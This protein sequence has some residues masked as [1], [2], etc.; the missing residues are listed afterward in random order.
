MKTNKKQTRIY[1][2]KNKRDKNTIVKHSNN[3]KY[4]TNKQGIIIRIMMK[5]KSIIIKP[6]K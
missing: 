1:M 6:Q 5:Q 3:T 4:Q 2:K